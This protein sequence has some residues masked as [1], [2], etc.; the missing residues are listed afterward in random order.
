MKLDNFIVL[1]HIE[2]EGLGL[3]EEILKKRN[4]G[5][6]YVKIHKKEPLPEKLENGTGLIVLGGPQSV[7]ER[8][9]YP[10]IAQEE[11]LIEIAVSRGLAV[12][13]ICLGSQLIASACGAEVKPGGKKE[14]GWHDVTLDPCD[15]DGC[16][17]GGLPKKIKVFHWHG[18]TF[19]IPKSGMRLA[20]SKEFANQAFRFGKGVLAL[21]FHL[22]V[23]EDMIKAWLQEY[24]KELAALKLDPKKIIEDS[25]KYLPA[26]KKYAET[27]FNNYLNTLTS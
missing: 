1:Q 19:D 23:T 6:R 14:I 9:K 5:F 17:F 27:I 3:F 10:F 13:G 21:Q 22:E 26:L 4:I 20:S 12:L 7:Y 16:F 8:N 15:M 2:C 24:K 18:D 25:K 11:H